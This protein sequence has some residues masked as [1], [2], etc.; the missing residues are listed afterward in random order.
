MRA[1]AELLLSSVCDEQP[2]AQD[3]TDYGDRIEWCRLRAR[4]TDP[5]SIGLYSASQVYVVE[6]EVIPRGKN[7]KA[8]KERCYAIT[9]TVPLAEGKINGQEL[10]KTFRGHWTVE[11]KNHYYQ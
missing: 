11:A 5:E 3:C 10:L 2:R 6:R 4:A 7:V 8:S 1:K 9:S